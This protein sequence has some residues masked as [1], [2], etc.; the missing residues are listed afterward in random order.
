MS[1]ITFATLFD[2][3]YLKKYQEQC[4]EEDVA[5]TERFA[6]ILRLLASKKRII[7]KTK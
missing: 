5:R 1:K 6:R 3:K 4:F 2:K 7:Y